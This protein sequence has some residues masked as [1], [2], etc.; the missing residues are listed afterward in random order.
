[1]NPNWQS[2]SF[3]RKTEITSRLIIRDDLQGKYSILID[4]KKKEWKVISSGGKSK[5]VARGSAARSSQPPPY[6]QTRIEAEVEHDPW[7]DDDDNDDTTTTSLKE[8]LREA[9]KPVGG[10]KAELVDR[11]LA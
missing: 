6:K 7:F 1:M 3:S 8:K 11:L 5:F 10:K 2:G 4:D 9:A